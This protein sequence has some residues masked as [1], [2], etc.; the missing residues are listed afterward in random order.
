MMSCWNID[1]TKRPTFGALEVTLSDILEADAG[2]VVLSSSGQKGNNTSESGH[3]TPLITTGIVPQR[4]DGYDQVQVPTEET[5]GEM[6]GSGME[7]EMYE[8]VGNPVMEKESVVR[9]DSH[10]DLDYGSTYESVM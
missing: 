9:H 3:Y 1:S 2:Y 4:D 7:E 6:V 5:L 8:D 10:R